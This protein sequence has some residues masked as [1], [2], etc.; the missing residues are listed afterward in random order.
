MNIIEALKEAKKGKKITR[1]VWIQKKSDDF[2]L[3]YHWHPL[4]FEYDEEDEGVKWILLDVEY[5][6][7][8]NFFTLDEVKAEN[9]EILSPKELK[10]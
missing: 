10:K 2:G 3:C 5:K 9:W 8:N 6:R 1:K 7:E 4:H